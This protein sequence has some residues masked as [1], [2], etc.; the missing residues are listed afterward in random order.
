MQYSCH[1]LLQNW[2]RPVSNATRPIL[3]NH[4]CSSSHLW[5]VCKS[6]LSRKNYWHRLCI[7]YQ[8][9]LSNPC[10]CHPGA[11]LA[12]VPKYE[13]LFKY[14][15]LFILFLKSAFLFF[16]CSRIYCYTCLTAFTLRTSLSSIL[17]LNSF[18]PF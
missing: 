12:R 7:S 8:L 10:H 9:T 6:T 1:R 17:L 18:E 5:F 16:S 13:L 3:T 15:L 14:S 11:I 4:Y 2:P